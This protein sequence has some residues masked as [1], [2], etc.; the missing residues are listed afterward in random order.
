MSTHQNSKRK[1]HDHHHSHKY[2]QKNGSPWVSIIFLFLFIG[3]FLVIFLVPWSTPY[4]HT[5]PPPPSKEEYEGGGS[6]E[7]GGAPFVFRKKNK[8]IAQKR[9]D[10]NRCKSGERWS[11]EE[12]MCEPIFNTPSSFEGSIMNVTMNMC[13]D[14][15]NA[16]CGKW[17]AEHTN[18]DRTFSYGYHRNQNRIRR[19][20]QNPT[21]VSIRSFYDSCITNLNGLD[22]HE[23]QLETQ[24]VLEHIAN[25]LKGY[26]DLPTVL[27]RLSR[28]GY[29]SPFVFSIE[30]D[31][32]QKRLVPFFTAGSFNFSSP[33]VMQTFETAR[34][35]TKHTSLVLMD[36]VRRTMKVINHL[37]QK[38]TEPVEGIV[39]YM[40]YLRS[41][42][43]ND[44]MHL[45]RDL[46][47]WNTPHENSGGWTLFFQ[48]LD[49]S[50]L[51]LSQEQP[52]WVIGLSYMKWLLQDGLRSVEVMDWVAFV[53]FS[54]LYN[55]KETAPILS[56]NVYLRSFS[57]SQTK[58]QTKSHLIL[59]SL[60]E[61][62]QKELYCVE[63]TQNMIPG[64][65]A[66]TFL[67]EMMP[68]KELIRSQVKTIVSRIIAVYRGFIQSSAWL[69]QIDK[70]AALRKLDTLIVRVVEPDEWEAEPFAQRISKDRYT[71]NMNMVR[72]Y[73]VHRNIQQWHLN[74][75]PELSIPFVAPLSDVNAYYSGPS[76]SITILAGILQKPFYNVDYNEPT[77]YAIIG[78]II[79]HEL[80][81]MFDP[82]G[83]LWDESGNFKPRG[84][85]SKEGMD[86]FQ[87]KSRCVVD[88]FGD[89]PEECIS[90]EEED[91]ESKE[92][93]EATLGEDLADLVGI[94][95]SY[96]AYFDNNPSATSGQRQYFF[97]SFAQ[98]WCS[99]YD[100][101][102]TCA[103]VKGDV[104]AIAEYR[105]DRT[106][107][108]IPEFARVFGCQR[109][110]NTCTI[111]E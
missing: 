57:K 93:G 45:F 38:N 77:R 75:E 42:G 101:K 13:D 25:A 40:D 90:E 86:A 50:A 37:N 95:L 66:Q 76:N 107:R 35:I 99:S 78:S 63:V 54:I 58:Y 92:Y 15:F 31:P 70:D 10:R 84:I 21:Y 55:I 4:Y 105:V 12:G 64:L 60:E 79:G 48:A 61:T 97:M 53:E 43:I 17:N 106:L 28:Y 73:R 87:N 89:T 102:H 6:G 18:E 19:I 56:N 51:R 74:K 8:L 39:D 24:H 69:K 9:S 82:H 96:K 14:F 7:G 91:S 2:H 72:R 100:V 44:D 20:V 65:V 11:P 81:H 23:S 104:H 47:L 71:H 67:S 68:N 62:Q 108:N 32:T 59:R 52:V 46:G 22:T 49:G 33:V 16:M 29:T 94:R 98:A 1:H 111:Y 103:L 3:V 110:N 85:W 26:G 5:H 27:G 88:E 36:K 41:G 83:L 34:S 30:R 80:G 109:K